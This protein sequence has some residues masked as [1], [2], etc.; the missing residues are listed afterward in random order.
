MVVYIL[1]SIPASAIIDIYGIR[2]LSVSVRFLTG[3]FGL[4]RGVMGFSFSLGD[5]CP[6]R[7]RNRPAFPPELND[8]GGCPVVS[9]P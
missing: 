2:M 1:V 8:D 5:G 7:H 3:I 4:M 9:D 6:D